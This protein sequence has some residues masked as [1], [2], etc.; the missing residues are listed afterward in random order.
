VDSTRHTSHDIAVKI[1]DKEGKAYSLSLLGELARERG[2]F[3][4]SQTLLSES[5]SLFAEIGDQRRLA[6]LDR[7]RGLT[8]LA[9]D[10]FSTANNRLTAALTRFEEIGDE[11]GCAKTLADRG[12][13]AHADGNST[14]ATSDLEEAIDRFR[15]IGATEIALNH[16]EALGYTL[17]FSPSA[18]SQFHSLVHDLRQEVASGSS[19]NI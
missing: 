6:K 3:E 2:N 16:V 9:Q 18:G 19:G 14:E 8:A 1:G 15:S 10:D 5:R 11:M 17:D 13:V 7:Q 12:R 4:R